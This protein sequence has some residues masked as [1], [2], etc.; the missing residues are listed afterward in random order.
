MYWIENLSSMCSIL[1]TIDCVYL[2]QRLFP[3]MIFNLYYLRV[4]ITTSE[5]NFMA[6][7]ISKRKKLVDFLHLLENICLCYIIKNTIVYNNFQFIWIVRKLLLS[8]FRL[9][10]RY[11][12]KIHFSNTTLQA[13]IGNWIFKISSLGKYTH[14]INKFCWK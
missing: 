8:C 11:A 14:R 7:Q 4:I 13:I 5:W 2:T 6:C 12:I 10:I 1:Q 9:I 3:I